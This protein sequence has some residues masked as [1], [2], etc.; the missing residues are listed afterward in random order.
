MT[1]GEI[2]KDLEVMLCLSHQHMSIIFIDQKQ[3]VRKFP[4]EPFH[5]KWNARDNNL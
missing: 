1:K 3:L 5:F 2:N 4:I